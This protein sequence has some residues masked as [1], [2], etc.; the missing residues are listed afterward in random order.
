M[1]ARE[2]SRLRLTAG[3]G[4]TDSQARLVR[5]MLHNQSPAPARNASL[6]DGERQAPANLAVLDARRGECRS[7]LHCLGRVKS[8]RCL[9]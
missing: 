8:A 2:R 3:S 6:N 9:A 1:M 5:V 7:S 4:G